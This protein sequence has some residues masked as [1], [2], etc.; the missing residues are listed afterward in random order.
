MINCDND[1]FYEACRAIGAS[2]NAGTIYDKKFKIE[3]STNKIEWD[4]ITQGL[5]LVLFCHLIETTHGSKDAFKLKLKTLSNADIVDILFIARNA[6]VHC[7]WDISK[8]DRP[9]QISKIKDFV[10]S[11]YKHSELDFKIS[12]SGDNLQITNLE[13]MCRT[14][15]T[16]IL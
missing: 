11:G 8:L 15:L 12:L 13:I 3:Y 16:D 9:N 7:K 5:L 2:F 6:F 1:I 14:L 10:G 4:K